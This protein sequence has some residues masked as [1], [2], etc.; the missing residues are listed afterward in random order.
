MTTAKT[1]TKKAPP[2][3]SRTISA[4]DLS[5]RLRLPAWLPGRLAKLG[6]LPAVRSAGRWVFA[7]EAEEMLKRL[8]ES[9]RRVHISARAPKK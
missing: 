2:I 6:L 8:L 4:T 1:P 5:S 3:V 9:A 7:A